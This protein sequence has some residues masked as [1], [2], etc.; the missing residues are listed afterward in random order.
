[1]E[2]CNCGGGAETGSK[3]FQYARRECSV[4]QFPVFP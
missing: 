3:P 4:F 1:M 2:N